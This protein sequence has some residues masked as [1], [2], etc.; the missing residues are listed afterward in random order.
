MCVS[1]SQLRLSRK[2]LTSFPRFLLDHPP[3][4]NQR[5]ERAN[6]LAN[7]R[8][9]GLSAG[10]VAALASDQQLKPKRAVSPRTSNQLRIRLHIVY[11][12]KFPTIRQLHLRERLIT[13]CEHSAITDT[14]MVFRAK[15]RIKQF[16]T[17]SHHD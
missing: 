3:N 11:W 17:T 10:W 5:S 12:Y 8:T 9:K 4:P 6:G 1:S 15:R 7:A 14:S 2:R 13:E 16:P